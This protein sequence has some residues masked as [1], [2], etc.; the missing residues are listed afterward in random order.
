MSTVAGLANHLTQVIPAGMLFPSF[1][2]PR[3]N[4]RKGE[5]F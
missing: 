1:L 2:Q 5:K 4:E 3:T